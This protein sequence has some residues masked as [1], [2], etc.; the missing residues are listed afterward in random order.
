[1]TPE[2]AIDR[3]EKLRDQIFLSYGMMGILEKNGSVSLPRDGD[4]V[5][6]L[7]DEIY[8]AGQSSS[9]DRNMDGAEEFIGALLINGPIWPNSWGQNVAAAAWILTG[10][11]QRDT[12]RIK[13]DLRLGMRWLHDERARQLCREIIIEGLEIHTPTANPPVVK[14][15]INPK[16][17]QLYDLRASLIR[18]AWERRAQARQL[19]HQCCGQAQSSL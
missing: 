1:M 3:A 4:W 11:G 12:Q 14:I 15:N 10:G 8:R 18:Q 5:K 16:L 13:H 19:R 7:A 2:Q 9:Q 6:W 17:Q